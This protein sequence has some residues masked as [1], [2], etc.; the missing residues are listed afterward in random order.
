MKIEK[1]VVGMNETNTYIINDE[2]NNE[3]LVIDPGDEAKKIMKYI[4]RNQLQPVGII[5]THFHHDHSG[6]AE[7]LKKKYNCPI[8]SHK[9]EVEGLKDPEFN[10]SLERCRKLISFAPDKTLSEENVITVGNIVLQII[11]TPG[12]TPGGICL[13]VK[14]SNIIFTGDTVFK[15][16]FGRTDL[17]GGNEEQLKKSITNKVAKWSDDIVI[18]PGHDEIATMKEVRRMNHPYLK[19]KK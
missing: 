5:L 1:I 8:Y 13:Q 15:D 4:D 6:A 12:H 11:H 10:R 19:A 7:E 16:G 14:E 2:E 17:P 9:K 3:A 18:Y